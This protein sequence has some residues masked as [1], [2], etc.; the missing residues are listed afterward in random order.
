MSSRHS[1]SWHM[2]CELARQV[3]DE[4]C[5]QP[6]QERTQPVITERRPRLLRTSPRTTCISSPS[7]TPSR[8]CYYE[9]MLTRHVSAFPA[10]ANPTFRL[11]GL[12]RHDPLPLTSSN[13]MMPLMHQPRFLTTLTPRPRPTLLEDG[14]LTS[15]AY[16]ATCHLESVHT[17][18]GRRARGVLTM[19]IYTPH[20]SS[21]RHRNP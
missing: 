21:P 13:N 10:A 3:V 18:C 4:T 7:T 19:E 20:S 9:T 17:H 16:R 14:S 12:P 6:R 1:G 11:T 5:H 2:P 15:L 8:W